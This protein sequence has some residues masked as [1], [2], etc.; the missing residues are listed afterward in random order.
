MSNSNKAVVASKISKP[1]RN[2]APVEGAK[3]K[4]K[5][6]KKWFGDGVDAAEQ[7]LITTANYDNVTK[8][9]TVFIDAHGSSSEEVFVVPPD[10]KI[11]T[12]T[13]YDNVMYKRFTSYL[14]G[15]IEVI[16]D[17]LLNS[18]EDY[19]QPELVLPTMIA[20]LNKEGQI[21]NNNIGHTSTIHVYNETD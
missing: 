15:N 9:N 3:K 1:M 6:R 11:I 2:A 18:N 7:G 17:S 10:N 16:N 20:G 21:N 14:Y 13:R 8:E 19:I 4:T 5:T 12:Y